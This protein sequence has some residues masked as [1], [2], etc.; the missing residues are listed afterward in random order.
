MSDRSSS[1]PPG[2][3]LLLAR[4]LFFAYAREILGKIINENGKRGKFFALAAEIPPH[5]EIYSARVTAHNKS[6]K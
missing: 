4:V 6:Q 2:A 1:Q 3:S 5:A